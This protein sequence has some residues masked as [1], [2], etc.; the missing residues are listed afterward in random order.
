MSVLTKTRNSVCK[1]ACST[2]GRP[3]ACLNLLCSLCTACGRAMLCWHFRQF[4]R[5]ITPSPPSP[6]VLVSFS[7][8]LPLCLSFSLSPSFLPFS[9]LLP[10]YLLPSLVPFPS[11]LL[12]TS[13]Y[14]PTKFH[15]DPSSSLGVHNRSQRRE[16]WKRLISEPDNRSENNETCLKTFVVFQT[17]M[18]TQFL[19]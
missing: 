1:R 13:M 16:I 19:F 18:R 14:H 5:G 9:L 10:P 2:T 11:L 3:T 8:F 17:S 7:L 6:E 15:V 4:F 12:L